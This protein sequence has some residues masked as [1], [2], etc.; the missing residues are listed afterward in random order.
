MAA[1]VQARAGKEQTG[2]P[3]RAYRGSLIGAG[4]EVGGRKGKGE[5]RDKGTPSDILGRET[6]RERDGDKKDREAETNRE[7][8]TEK[9]RESK[10]REMGG[11]E[12]E[13]EE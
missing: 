3:G 8:D 5:K 10:E 7:R 9:N 1:S 6:K 13:E 2:H 4:K 11:R 12:N